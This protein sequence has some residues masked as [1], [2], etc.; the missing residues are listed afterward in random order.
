MAT[1]KDYGQPEKTAGN[2]PTA[3]ESS[4]TANGLGSMPARLFKRPVC[5]ALLQIARNPFF[6]SRLVFLVTRR[7]VSRLA[8]RVRNWARH[9]GD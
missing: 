1:S 8:R 5:I 9:G 6:F 4:Q 2:S 7:D 3:G